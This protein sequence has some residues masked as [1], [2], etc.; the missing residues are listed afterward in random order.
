MLLPGSTLID[1]RL[2]L[3]LKMERRKEREKNMKKER[4]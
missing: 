3:L 4:N 1:G 2:K